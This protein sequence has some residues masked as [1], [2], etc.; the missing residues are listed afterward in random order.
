M[1]TKVKEIFIMRAFACSSVVLLHSIGIVQVTYELSI[2]VH[3]ILRA[4]QLLLLYATPMFVFMSEFVLSYSY[5]SDLPKGFFKKRLRYILVPYIF[6]GIFYALVWAYGFSIT[7]KRA[8]LGQIGLYVFRGDYHGYFVLII[9]QFYLLHKIFSKR[10]D[11]LPIKATLIISMLFNILYLAFFNYTVWLDY[12]HIPFARYI[13]TRGYFMLF[14]AWIFYF[15]LAYYAGQRVETFYKITKKFV[16]LLIPVVAGCGFIILYQYK[17]ELLAVISTKRPDVV[18]YTL[19]AIMLFFYGSSFVQRIPKGV[20]L[21]NRCS[22]SIY[23]LHPFVQQLIQ[24]FIIRTNSLRNPMS[25]LLAV[26]I[27]SLYVPILITIL[28]NRW[29]LGHLLVGNLGPSG[30]EKEIGT[31]VLTKKVLP[32]ILKEVKGNLIS[33]GS[34]KENEETTSK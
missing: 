20:D 12:A 30:I 27:L 1:N 23:L 32:K 7:D 26:F 31:G 22:Y 24:L 34:L 5:G 10:L 6:F 15:I 28:V 14:P 8:I 4:L 17:T 9:F 13:W 19:A 33:Q 16:C 11:R 25:A 29:P 21:I 2:S 3:S 18:P